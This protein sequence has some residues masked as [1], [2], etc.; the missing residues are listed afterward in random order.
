MAENG[1]EHIS[2]G[3]GAAVRE[4]NPPCLIGGFRGISAT[5]PSY[6]DSLHFDDGTVASID[7]VRAK[8]TLTSGGFDWLMGHADTFISEDTTSWA[9][10]LIPGRWIQQWKYVISE[11]SVALGVGF[12]GPSCKV[13]ERTAFIEFNPNKTAGN[14]MF[15]ALIAHVASVTAKAEIRRFDLAYDVPVR[16][17]F[18]RL[19]KDRRMYAAYISNGMTETLGVRNSVGHVRCYDK[20]AEAG[21]DGDLTR[22][23][24][25]CS[26][27]W[28]ADQIEGSWPEVHSWH[29]A[30]DSCR[31]QTKLIGMLLSEKAERGE[32]VESFVAM[33]DHRTRAKVRENLTSPTIELPREAAEYGVA[34]S[35]TWARRLSVKNR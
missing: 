26:G 27:E 16:K 12:V 17:D 34:E 1:T 7:N 28:S 24:L 20:S 19:T 9:S 5:S 8:L 14:S 23:E 33:L 15:D 22:I 31:S 4:G 13:S 18:A 30:D 25:T 6:F 2:D 21:L 32:E 29:A 11:S 3:I 35:R 10:K